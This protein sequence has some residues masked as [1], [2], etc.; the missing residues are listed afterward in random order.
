MRNP[1]TP[2]RISRDAHDWADQTIASAAW[3][4]AAQSPDEVAIYLED[5][6]HITYGAIAEEAL[7]LVTGL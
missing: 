6:P 2:E 7:R 3:Q 1:L 4:R 5:E